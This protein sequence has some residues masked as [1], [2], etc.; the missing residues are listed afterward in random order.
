MKIK[1]KK[2]PRAF[3]VGQGSKITLNDCGELELEANELITL[4][5]KEGSRHDIC[6]KDF[7]FYITMSLNRRVRKDGFRAALMRNRSN[8]Y[9]IVLVE[10]GK[11]ALFN[12][13]LKEENQDIVSWLDNDVNLKKI[14]DH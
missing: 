3:N 8:D 4:V 10:D 5:T 12:A 1:E 7:G 13:Y 14:S 2:P 6:R 9:Y 11:E